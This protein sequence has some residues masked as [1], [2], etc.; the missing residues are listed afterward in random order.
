M[1]AEGKHRREA[2][3]LQEQNKLLVRDWIIV[4]LFE[5][6]SFMSQVSSLP[7]PCWKPPWN[8]TRM[9]SLRGPLSL[10]FGMCADAG[11]V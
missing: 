1:E 7:D 6:C 3:L 2:T 10:Y 8:G 4:V 9:P 5:E 11:G